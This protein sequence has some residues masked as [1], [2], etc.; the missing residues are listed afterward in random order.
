VVEEK[1]S[2]TECFQ[3]WLAAGRAY[4]LKN[5]APITCHGK[6]F[7]TTPLPSLLSLLVSEKNMVGWYKTGCMEWES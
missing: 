3:H 7:S 4:G 1:M 5:S 2:S 6:Y